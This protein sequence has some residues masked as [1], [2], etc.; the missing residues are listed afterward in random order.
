MGVRDHALGYHP[1]FEFVKCLGRLN[2][3]PWVVGAVAWWVGYCMAFIQQRQRLIP[4]ALVEHIQREQW[5][6][7]RV[8]LT[9]PA[10]KVEDGIGQN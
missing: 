4:E 8:L 5:Q 1:L 9:F 2:E 3:P 6:R 7:I 10:S